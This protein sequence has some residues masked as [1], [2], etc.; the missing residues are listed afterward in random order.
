MSVVGWEDWR[1]Y[2]FTFL[3]NAQRFELGTENMV[4][5]V[6][7]LAAVRFLMEIGIPAIERWTLHLTDLLIEDLQR[8]GYRVA[9]SLA[10]KH[11]SAIVSFAVDGDPDEAFQRLQDARVAVSKR[12]EYIRVSPHCYNTE[13]EIARVGDV[14][15]NAQK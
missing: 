15:G 14:L 5:Q 12:E 8:R 4:G 3:P 13:Q 6:G 7:L 2:D 10:S 11:R 1:D 9:S